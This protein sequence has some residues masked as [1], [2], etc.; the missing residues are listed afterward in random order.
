MLLQRQQALQVVSRS[1]NVNVRQ[2]SSHPLRDWLEV[3]QSQEWIQPNELADPPF[4]CTQLRGQNARI[5]GV[6]TITKNHE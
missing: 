5:S 3:F 6:P 1:E 2:S 4:H